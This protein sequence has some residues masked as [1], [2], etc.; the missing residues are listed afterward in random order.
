MNRLS[1]GIIGVGMV[2][3][4]LKR[5]FEEFKGYKRGEDLFLYDIDPKKGYYD[6]INQAD[7]IF[8]SVPTPSSPDGS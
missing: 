7:V 4:P 3:A 6:D 8:I 1:I 2:G 5:Y